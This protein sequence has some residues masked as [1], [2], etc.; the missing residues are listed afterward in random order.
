MRVLTR[1]LLK[2]RRGMSFFLSIAAMAATQVTLASDV[3]IERVERDASGRAITVLEPP[4]SVAPGDRLIFVLS[5]RNGGDAP[6]NDFLVTNPVPDAVAF[7]G[8][9]GT[10]P[11]VSVDW[12]RSWG[13]LSSLTI[14]LGD[15]TARPAVPA[16]VTHVR[17]SIRRALAAG[18]TGKLS[19]R[20]V[21][22]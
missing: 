22:R 13:A 10:E 14:K 1:R 15:G 16:D 7:A 21:A 5:Y 4:K 20:A 12:G 18:E 2:E 17:W 19:F 9:D 8:A 6:A 11:E 3:F